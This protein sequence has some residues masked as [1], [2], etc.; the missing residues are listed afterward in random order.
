[1]C[2]C[3]CV[4]VGGCVVW[5]A[6]LVCFRCVRTHAC[7]YARALA[8]SIVGSAAA[9][10]LRPATTNAR[11]ANRRVEFHLQD[12]QARMSMR[13]LLRGGS[14]GSDVGSAEGAGGAPTTPTT[15]QQL[16]AQA[17]QALGEIASGRFAGMNLRVRACAADVMLASGVEWDVLRVL[18]IAVYKEDRPPRGRCPAALLTVH[19]MRRVMRFYFLLCK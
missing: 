2:V 5:S 17:V 3:V 11:Q 7:A 16:D 14:A 15:A 12:L 18:Y 4:C 19:L 13:Q 10:A 9:D 8:G 6:R 1:M